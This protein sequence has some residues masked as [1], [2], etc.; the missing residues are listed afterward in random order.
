MKI[1]TWNVTTLRNNNHID[2]RLTSS[3]ASNRIY[4]EFQKLVSQV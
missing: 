3:E 2:A 4:Q 1:V